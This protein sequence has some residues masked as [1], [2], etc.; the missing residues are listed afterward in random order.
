MGEWSRGWLAGS[1]PRGGQEGAGHAGR[2]HPRGLEWREDL[3]TWML[4]GGAEAEEE[5]GRLCDPS[6]R[7]MVPATAQTGKQW[8]WGQTAP[9]TPCPLTLYW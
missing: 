7:W 4:D 2:Q 3:R 1:L 8:G 6:S 5:G 9:A